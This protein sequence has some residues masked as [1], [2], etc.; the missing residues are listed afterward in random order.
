MGNYIIILVK[1][2]YMTDPVLYHHTPEETSELISGLKEEFV[3]ELVKLRNKL[4]ISKKGTAV[5]AKMIHEL[6]EKY[7]N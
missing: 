4:E 5:A 7:D 2:N 1:G 6:I 3:L